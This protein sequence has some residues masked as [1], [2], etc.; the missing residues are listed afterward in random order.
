MKVNHIYL[1]PRS[2]SHVHFDMLLNPFPYLFG[3]HLFSSSKFLYTKNKSHFSNILSYE[4]KLSKEE[5]IPRIK[6]GSSDFLDYIYTTGYLFFRIHKSFRIN[7]ILGHSDSQA[8]TK[9]YS[10]SQSFTHSDKSEDIHVGTV[11]RQ[12]AICLS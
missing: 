5:S 10:N 6:S 3:K 1:S 11:T 4:K 12:F 7:C 2:F 8:F 9:G